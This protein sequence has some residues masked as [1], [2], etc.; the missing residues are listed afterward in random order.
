MARRQASLRDKLRVEPGQALDLGKRD[1]RATPLAPG[2]KSVTR[3]AMAEHAVTLHALQETFYA[4]AAGGGRRRILLVLQGVDTS[5]KSGVVEHVIGQVNPQGVQIASFRRP[6]AE[7]EKHHF[8]WRIRRQLPK[9]GII[10]IFNGSHYE[11]VLLPRVHQLVAPDVLDRRYAEIKRFEHQLSA[12]GVTVVK[13][14]LHLS[15]DEQRERLLARLDDPTKHWKVDERDLAERARW[16]DYQEAY[17]VALERCSTAEAAWYVVPADRKWY[18]NWAVAA[19]VREE[20]AD[21][22]LGYP[23]PSFD[24]DAERDRLR[25][26]GDP[27]T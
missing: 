12:D 27:P 14:F 19:L 23:K 2:G 24:V 22:R 13:C 1:P 17:R 3:A 21:L 6:T 4:E 15:Y 7:E 25:A 26:L 5:G 11:D 9:P 10:G 16:D 18:R 20:F 8:L